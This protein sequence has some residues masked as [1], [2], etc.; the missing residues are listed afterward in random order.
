MKAHDSWPGNKAE[1]G[2]LPS[3]ARTHTRVL[4]DALSNAQLHMGFNTT[5]GVCCQTGVWSL[6][7]P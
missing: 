4:Q 2:R 1:E 3:R 6:I 7:K 5:S